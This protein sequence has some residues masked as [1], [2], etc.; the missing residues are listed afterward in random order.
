MTM[1][2]TN[3]QLTSF[4]NLI[5]RYKIV[6]PIIQRD[7][8]QGRDEES[9]LRKRFLSK[10]KQTLDL[11]IIASEP[12]SK[13][14]QPHQLIL[15]FVYGTP[16]ENGAI[17]PLDGQQRLTTLW[18]LH[19]YVAY[20]SGNLSDDVRNVLKSFSYETRVSSRDFA[21]NCVIWSPLTT[22]NQL[23]VP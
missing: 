20:I 1:N 17:A 9:P 22:V 2:Q 15:D 19:W 3:K 12:N 16:A 11:A 4:W 10:L 8:A 14:T 23:I 5:K 18:L 6:I 21:K 7:Y 13:T